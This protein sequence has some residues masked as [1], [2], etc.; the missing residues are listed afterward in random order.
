VDTPAT[1]AQPVSV[2]ATETHYPGGGATGRVWGL[3][4]NDLLTFNTDSGVSTWQ[5]SLQIQLPLS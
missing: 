5:A 3:T 1:E 4:G 2:S